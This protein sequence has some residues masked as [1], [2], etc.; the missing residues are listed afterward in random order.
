MKHDAVK[1]VAIVQ[2]QMND[3]QLPIFNECSY[4]QLLFTLRALPFNIHNFS[5][6]FSKRNRVWISLILQSRVLTLIWSRA[7]AKKG[8]HSDQLIVSDAECF[9][10]VFFTFHICRCVRH[11]PDRLGPR[12]ANYIC[13]TGIYIYYLK[14]SAMYSKIY[15]ICVLLHNELYY[16]SLCL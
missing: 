4:K 6:L 2:S 7:N 13:N 3:L 16:L 14:V 11:D 12:N 10:S 9:D 1:A 5:V 8:K 15:Q